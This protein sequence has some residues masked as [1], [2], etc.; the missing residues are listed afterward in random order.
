MRDPRASVRVEE[1]PSPGVV[2]GFDFGTRKIGLA[3]G[4]RITGMAAP[5]CT[6]RLGNAG[7]P[8]KTISAMVALW[9]PALFVVGLA[10]QLDGSDNLITED[11]RRFCRHLEKRYRLPVHTIDETLSTAESRQRFFAER[12][13]LRTR[14]LQVK[15][16]L[17]A[18][19]I[20]QTWLDQTDA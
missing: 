7:E 9:R 13:N 1:S 12:R 15:D 6:I 10:C 11:I 14:F 18:Q 17:A 4:Q 2:I 20:L 19:V 8:W 16:E 3:I 5:L